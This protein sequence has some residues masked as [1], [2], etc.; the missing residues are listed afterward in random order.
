LTTNDGEVWAQAHQVRQSNDRL[1]DELSIIEGQKKWLSAASSH[2]AAG[3]FRAARE[4]AAK[5]VD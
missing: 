2:E 5:L 1:A 4:C 3:S